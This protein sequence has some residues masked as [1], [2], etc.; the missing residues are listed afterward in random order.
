M[1][2]RPACGYFSSSSSHIG[3]RLTAIHWRCT[4]NRALGGDRPRDQL[5]AG[6]GARLVVDVLGRIACAVFN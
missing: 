1:K 2:L 5:D 3:I 6:A 4:A